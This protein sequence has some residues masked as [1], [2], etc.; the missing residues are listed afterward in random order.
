MLD[1]RVEIGRQAYKEESDKVLG[2]ALFK[3]LRKRKR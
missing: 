1:R 3:M 2:L